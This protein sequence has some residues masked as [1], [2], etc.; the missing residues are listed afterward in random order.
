[1]LEQLYTFQTFNSHV[2]KVTDTMS[3]KASLCAR[4]NNGM[5]IAIIMKNKI[6]R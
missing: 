2:T 1:M 6:K 3:K 4:N 5:R